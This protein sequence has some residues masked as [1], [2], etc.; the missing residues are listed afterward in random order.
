VAGGTIIETLSRPEETRTDGAGKLVV[1]HVAPGRYT[2][3]LDGRQVGG[4]DVHDAPVAKRIR[5]D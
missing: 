2:V 3:H 5:V 1:D 4:V